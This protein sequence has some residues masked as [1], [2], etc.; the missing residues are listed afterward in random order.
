MKS[1]LSII[2]AGFFLS[3][4]TDYK[5]QIIVLQNEKQELISQSIYKDSTI[6]GFVASINEIE[7]GIIAITEKQKLVK[8]SGNTEVQGDAKARIMTD[9]ADIDK[10]LQENKDK[11]ASLSRRLKGSS[12]KIDGLEKMITGLNNQLAVKDSE[13]VVLNGQ[14]AVLNNTVTTLNNKVEDLNKVT[15]DKVKTIE[16]QTSKL[17]TAYYTI[18]TYK[19]LLAK[20]IVIKEGGFLGMGKAELVKKDFDRTSFT[21]V[22]ITKLSDIPVSGKEVLI[23]T[24]HPSDSYSLTKDSKKMVTGMVISNPEKFWSASKYLVVQENK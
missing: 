16:D 6:T 22:D 24:N 2:I 15:A 19:D 12:V 17:N 18:G 9:L 21:T 7:Q 10:L 20:K 1:I 5:S 13:M 14:I 11:I 4:C 8:A 3:G 23:L